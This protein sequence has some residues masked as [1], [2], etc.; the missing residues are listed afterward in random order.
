MGYI[1]PAMGYYPRN[2]QMRDIDP[3]PICNINQSNK[4]YITFIQ[5]FISI[6]SQ[7]PI[8]QAVLT[9]TATSLV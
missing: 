6:K 7:H 2:G 8:R 4:Q 5:G 1:T 3:A 9:K